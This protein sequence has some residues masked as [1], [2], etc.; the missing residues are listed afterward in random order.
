MLKQNSILACR[1]RQI[2]KLMESCI[3]SI[4]KNLVCIPS[5]AFHGIP[6]LLGLQELFTRLQA[7]ASRVSIINSVMRRRPERSFGSVRV[8]GACRAIMGRQKAGSGNATSACARPAD[9]DAGR[10][11]APD[12]SSSS[13]DQPSDRRNPC[14]G[15]RRSAQGERSP[16]L[17][18]ASAKFMAFAVCTSSGRSFSTTCSALVFDPRRMSGSSGPGGSSRLGRT[19][20]KRSGHRR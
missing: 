14:V 18:G 19:K 7:I 2:S 15:G 4:R 3:V 12:P 9:D 13:L 11:R 10:S 16:S 5:K 1:S 6:P 8:K 20:A 17:W